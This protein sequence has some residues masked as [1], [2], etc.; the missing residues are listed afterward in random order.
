MLKTMLCVALLICVL[1]LQGLCMP[2]SADAY[3]TASRQTLTHPS[4]AYPSQDFAENITST[5]RL[6]IVHYW[7]RELQSDY[8]RERKLEPGGD[9]A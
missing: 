1:R 5:T 2:Y 4:A 7:R 9:E 8:W 3:S 6:K